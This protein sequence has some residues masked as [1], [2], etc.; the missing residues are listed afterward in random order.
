MKIFRVSVTL[1]NGESVFVGFTPA[2][3]KDDALRKLGLYPSGSSPTG[4]MFSI[5][6]G[7][8]VVIGLA[9]VK[10]P[11]LE[12]QHQL[13]SIIADRFSLEDLALRK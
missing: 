6:G 11:E 8:Y 9:E 10:G 13:R 2:E 5:G 1:K 7:N 12:G 4:L 3:S